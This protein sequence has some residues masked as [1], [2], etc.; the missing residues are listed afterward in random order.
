MRALALSASTGAILLACVFAAGAPVTAAEAEL[1]AEESSAEVIVRGQSTV[2]LEA[3]QGTLSVRVGR[4]GEMRFMART[5]DN[6]RAEQPVALWLDGSTFRM[7]P[8]E[9]QE[10]TPTLLEMSVAPELRIEIEVDDSTVLATEIHSDLEVRGRGLEITARGLR[11]SAEFAISDSRIDVNSVLGSLELEGSGIEGKVAR[12]GGGMSAVLTTSRLEIDDVTGG[13]DLEFEDTTLVVSTL[14]TSTEIRLERGSVHASKIQGQ[15][16]LWLSEAPLVIENSNAV[17]VNT[18]AEVRFSNVQQMEI[19][20][21]AYGVPVRGQGGQRL[22]LE[23]SGADVI[24]AKIGGEVRIRGEELDIHLTEPGGEVTITTIGSTVLVEKAAGPITI[25]NDFGEVTVRN[26]AKA[27]RI[28]N[29]NGDVNVSALRAP[30]DL[31]ADSER[32]AVTWTAMSGEG[33]SYVENENGDVHVAFPPNGGGRVKA[34]SRYGQIESSLEAIQIADDGKS[35]TGVLG[36]SE[37]P[38]IQVR[39]GGDLQIAPSAG[40]ARRSP[41]KGKGRNRPPGSNGQ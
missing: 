32:I 3:F 16:N 1:L 10:S 29:R 27:V 41:P 5:L 38:V 37:R 24:L 6:R 2:S 15:C 22:E 9:G 17:T 18:D 40:A 4:P 23:T 20:A 35:A 25:E 34:E 28:V 33:D 11:G 8:L 13:T 36:R 12:V 19:I 39:A 21:D 7:R 31:R 14:R 30:I 26:A